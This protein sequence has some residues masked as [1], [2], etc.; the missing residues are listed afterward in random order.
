MRPLSSTGL[1]WSID[2]E[3]ACEKHAP[4]PDDARW[5]SEWWE[6][7]PRP[8][9]HCGWRYQCQHCAVDGRKVIYSLSK[10]H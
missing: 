10:P 4:D 1:Y 5:A 6:P 8:S 2:G 7:V 9:G 3:V